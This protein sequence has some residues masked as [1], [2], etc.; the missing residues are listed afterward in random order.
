MHK[1]NRERTSTHL[2]LLRNLQIGPPA[3]ALRSLWRFREN[4]PAPSFSQ[5]TRTG[6]PH[7]RVQRR[8]GGVRVG[9]PVCKLC[10]DR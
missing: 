4:T 3:R 5:V 7:A 9:G 1:V 8:R 6:T 10:G 2:R